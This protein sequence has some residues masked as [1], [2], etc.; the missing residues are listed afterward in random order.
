[1]NHAA[2]FRRCLEDLDVKGIQKLWKHVQPNLPQPKNDRDASRVG[3]SRLFTRGSGH[4]P[5]VA[6]R[7]R[8]RRSPYCCW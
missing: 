1:M 5:G 7:E 3:V 6:A 8:A 2:E 4:V